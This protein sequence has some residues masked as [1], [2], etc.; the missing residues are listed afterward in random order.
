MATDHISTEHAEPGR[1]E[2]IASL[3]ASYR[4]KYNQGTNVI[5]NVFHVNPAVSFTS[6]HN[7]ISAQATA[8]ISEGTVLV[9]VPDTERVSLSNVSSSVKTL[10]KDIHDKYHQVENKEVE[11]FGCLN[12]MYRYGDICL[13]VAMM[14]DLTKEEK[15]YP[16]AWPSPKDMRESHY[17]LWDP[18][19]D[20][21]ELL[22]GTYTF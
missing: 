14:Y 4:V 12:D 11:D 7:G 22:K 15:I 18:K 16:K 8:A 17:P 3:I 13:A 1:E 6:T 10:L 9:R 2:A 20:V 21:Q 5:T 19:E